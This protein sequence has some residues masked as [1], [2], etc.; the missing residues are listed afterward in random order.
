MARSRARTTPATG[1]P[2]HLEDCWDEPEARAVRPDFELLQGSWTSAGGRRQA[3][4]LISGFH[5]TLRFADGDIYMGSFALDTNARPRGMTVR[6]DEGPARHRGLSALCIYEVAGDELRWC[7]PGP[8]A[9][10]PTAFAAIDD[11]H[12]LCLVFRREPPP[13][14]R[15]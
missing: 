12:F 14:A 3:E 6:I 8:G 7:T 1:A 9:E 13:K 11:P 5:F 15:G 2:E 10:L 4:F